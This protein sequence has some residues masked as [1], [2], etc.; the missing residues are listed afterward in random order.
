MVAEAQILGVGEI[1]GEAKQ[2]IGRSGVAQRSVLEVSAPSIAKAVQM[3]MK[4]TQG[5]AGGERENAR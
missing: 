4:K 1:W 3:E 5:Q 2:G